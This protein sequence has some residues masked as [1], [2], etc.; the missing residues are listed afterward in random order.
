MN[1]EYYRRKLQQAGVAFAPGLTD[2]E[3]RRAEDCHAFRFPPDL[4][5]LLMFALPISKGW[6]N[7]RDATNPEI[8]ARMA[9]PY[10]G[11]CFDIEHNVFWLEEWGPKPSTNEAAFAIA[12]KKIDEAPKLIPICGHRY[13]PSVPSLVGNPVFSVYQTDIIHY[14]AD[15]PNYLENE[16]YYYFETPEYSLKEP[17]RRI[18]FW[19]RLVE[20]NNG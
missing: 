4:R 5:D 1:L 17:I 3:A 15:L 19:T 14:G 13:I 10:E 2:S 8:E 12:R 6:P 7:W 9:W 11:I 18:E 20:L 16:F